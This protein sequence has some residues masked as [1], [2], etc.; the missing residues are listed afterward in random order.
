MNGRLRSETVVAFVEIRT[1]TFKIPGVP[2]GYRPRG[3]ADPAHPTRSQL[4][5]DNP[6]AT[7]RRARP[8]PAQMPVL[9]HPEPATSELEVVLWR[10]H[11]SAR[12][13]PAGEDGRPLYGQKFF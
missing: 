6:K 2:E 10:H 9:R 13:F 12:R 1:K 4:D 5:H 11:G 3:A 8:Q 7:Y